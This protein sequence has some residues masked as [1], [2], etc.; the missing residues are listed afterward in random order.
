[1]SKKRGQYH[2]KHIAK[3]VPKALD[4][5]LIEI[6]V[7]VMDVNCTKKLPLALQTIIAIMRSVQGTECAKK[8]LHRHYRSFSAKT[9]S[10]LCI[11]TLKER[12]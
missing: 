8:S 6:G 7:S 3:K 5:N 2:A 1:M 12:Y 4:S 10:I 9:G 11:K